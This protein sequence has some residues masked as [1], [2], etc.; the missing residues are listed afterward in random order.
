MRKYANFSGLELRVQSCCAPPFSLSH[1]MQQQ[2]LLSSLNPKQLQAVTAPEESVLILAGAGSGK[3]R[4]LTSRIAYLLNEQLASTSEIL[5]V[6]F[7]NKAAKE[8]VTRLETM[9]PYDL[10]RM[11][12]GTFHGLCN[13]ILRRHA[14]FAALPKTFQILDSGDQ[15]SL[16]KRVMK[17]ANV[18]PE[19]TDAKYVQ[20]FINW[21]KEHGLRANQVGGENC[22]ETTKSLYVEYERQCQREGVV[23]FAELL[24]RCY[25]LLERNELV[26]T[27]YQH[28]FRHILVDEFQDTNI[29]Q[30]RWLKLLA[31]AGLGPDGHSLNAVFAVGDDDQSI[32][33]F[34]GANVGNM[35]DFLEDFKVVEPIRLEENYRSTGT[36]LD[37]ANGLISKNSGRLGKNLWTSGA[38]GDKIVV[39]EMENDRAEA[40]WVVD[41]IEHERRRRNVYRDFA[42]L[43]R[44]NSQSR[45]MESAL[46]AAGIP[47]RVYG[48]LRFFERAEVKH[49]LAYLRLMTNPWDDTS[50][51]RIVNFPT[52]GIGAKTI[53]ALTEAA[54]ARGVSLWA[55]LSDDTVKVPP[56]LAAFHSLILKMRTDAQ[57]MSLD[58][59]IR[60][61]IS[62]SGLRDA[63]MK[64]KD[65]EDRVANMDE[66]LNAAKG[67]LENEGI[68]AEQCAFAP[69][70]EDAPSP[71][72]G[73]LTQATLEAGD[74]NEDAGVDAV[75]LMT[76]HAAKGLEFKYVYII[77]AEEGIFPHFSAIKSGDE[78]NKRG[79]LEEERR[80]MYVAITRAKVRLV[81]SHCRERLLYGNTFR[82][83]VS[84]F[85]EEI[86]ANLLDVRKLAPEREE[87][88]DDGVDQYFDDYRSGSRGGYGGY[89]SSYGR[90]GRSS[91]GD[92]Y[93]K[94]RSGGYGY[95][96]GHSGGYGGNYSGSRGYAASGYSRSSFGTR[97]GGYAG[98]SSGYGG[99]ASAA[100]IRIQGPKPVSS[101][102]AVAE[103]GFA[104]GDHVS[105]TN[106]GNGVVEQVVGTGKDCR[107]FI[108]FADKSRELLLEFA[109][110]RLK[111]LSD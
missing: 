71:I 16:I 102:S 1:D 35:E 6:T 25:E 46:A 12:V 111:K 54:R 63:Y 32:Y 53:E 82:N 43:Y 73:F 64:E 18:D 107:I 44:M 19:K 93:A 92:N 89:G 17:A 101:P 87:D 57:T 26:R 84:S 67:Y 31:G 55:A 29:L 41:D 11:W 34:R 96:S 91:Y 90:S 77:G 76:V 61:T 7:T 4:V 95:G 9:L 72:E 78:Q 3:T 105:H 36:I 47:Y 58:K 97:D 79:G 94:G 5:A 60:Y 48:G 88:D 75:Q 28:R 98:R 99:R 50:F 104:P 38:R 86:P 23:D 108:R 21:S 81:I 62:A 69:Y 30:Y 37:A 52:R 106:F 14:E 33:A 45:A 22:D 74:K 24:L 68:P 27:H 15:L 109:R 39:E 66:I 56:K 2:D 70:S 100:G 49:V 65:G 10:R 110:P 8:M 20:N 51:L 40:Q 80:L 103:A 13:R 59:A 85:I 42:V 83:P